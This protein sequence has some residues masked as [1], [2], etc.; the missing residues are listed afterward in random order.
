MV[1]IWVLWCCVFFG[2]ILTGCQGASDSDVGVSIEKKSDFPQ[3]L[4]GT[5]KANK[6]N[7]EFVFEPDGTISSAVIDL[8]A[9]R[10]KPGQ[11]T[12]IPLKAGGKGV[13]EAG[14][15]IVDYDSAERVLTVRLSLENFRME[16]GPSAL[17]GSSM[18][19]FVGRIDDDSSNIWYADWTGMPDYTI[20]T[21][22]RPNFKLSTDE[23]KTYGRQAT[24]IFE[25]VAP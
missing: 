17:E 16:M 2:L 7:W 3:F 19:I 6:D 13:F 20:H 25:K 10:I 23:E 21:P 12:T 1:R 5:W 22:E 14:E 11:I 9:T 4:V 15:C 8:G 24:L 18:N